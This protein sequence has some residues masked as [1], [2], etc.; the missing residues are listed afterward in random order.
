[1][2]ARMCV[3]CITYKLVCK[4]KWHKYSEK[5]FAVYL[6]TKNGLIIQPSN[7]TLGHFSQRNKNLFSCRNVC[8]TYRSFIHN[9]QNVEIT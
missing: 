7:C 1:M 6:K 9:S 3:N 8:K 5:Q 2:L 4:S